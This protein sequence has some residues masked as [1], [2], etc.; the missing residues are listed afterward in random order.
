M[1][2]EIIK[3]IEAIDK[4][5]E[6]C[7]WVKSHNTDSYFKELYSEITELQK[8]IENNDIDNIKEEL[9]DVLWDLVMLIRISENEF[10]IDSKEIV[11]DIIKKIKRRKPHVFDGKILSIEETKKNWKEAK[12]KEKNK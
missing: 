8:A 4:N 1:K 7:E 9:G 6:Y 11:N 12:K 3:L 5:I 2:G 10:N